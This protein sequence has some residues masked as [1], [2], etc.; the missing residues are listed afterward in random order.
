MPNR[1]EQPIVRTSRPALNDINDSVPGGQAS[2]SGANI[3][4][5]QLGQRVWLDGNPGGVRYD[6]AIGTLYGGCYQYV[7]AYLSSTATPAKGQLCAWAYDQA[8]TAFEAYIVTP[9]TNSVIRSGR[10]AGVFLDTVTKG[11]YGWIQTKGKATVLFTTSIAKATPA[12]GDLVIV[13]TSTGNAD[14]NIDATTVS[15]QLLKTAIGTAIGAS[16][17]NTT[18]LVLLK[19]LGDVI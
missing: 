7:Q 1:V 16:V 11:N 9:D 14:V 15:W 13:N 19:G 2:I 3:Y 5:A 8:P 4:A 17:S 6:T 12:D 10:I 18:N